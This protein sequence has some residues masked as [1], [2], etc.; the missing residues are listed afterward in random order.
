M[1]AAQLD[2]VMK[3]LG[4]GVNDLARMCDVDRRVV[5]RWLSDDSD[6]DVPGSVATLLAVMT[7]HRMGLGDVLEA[8]DGCVWTA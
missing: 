1:T 4:I 3:G 8:K 7:Y 6:K 5:A 2:E